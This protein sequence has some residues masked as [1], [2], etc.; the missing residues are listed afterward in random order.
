MDLHSA[1]AE[2]F[3]KYVMNTKNRKK[4]VYIIYGRTVF[5]VLA[6][7][8]QAIVLLLCFTWLA[9]Y[10]VYLTAGLTVL[11]AALIVYI[12]N[13]KS[14][15]AFKLAWIIPIL[16]FPV[17]GGLIYIFLELQPGPRH[18]RKKLKQIQEETCYL[19]PKNQEAAKRLANIDRQAGNLSE[20]LFR[21][22]GYPV[23]EDTEL[24]YFPQ[25]EDKFA[26]L[27]RELEK[28][29]EFIFLEY[30]ILEEG[31]MWD[32]VLEVLKRKAA[33]GVEVRL[34]YD[35]MCCLA[36][37]PYSY[38]SYI[39]R[40]GI[41]CKMFQPIAPVLDTMQNNRD[42]R[43]ILVID[44]KVAFTGGINFADEYINRKIRFGHWKD[45]AIMLKGEAVKSFTL[46]FLQMWNITEKTPEKYER[47]IKAPESFGA[48]REHCPGFVIP[49]GDSPLD[50]ENV[51]EHLYMDILNT[52][53]NYVHIMTPYLIIDNE[54]ITALLYAAK[55]G[56]EVQILLPHIPDKKL[57]FML[58]HSYYP[59]LLEG[60]V[61][62]YEYTPGFIHAKVF[63]SDGKEAVVGTV[64]LDYRSF[65]LHFE[66]GAYLYGCR[67]IQRIEQ[68]F[69][70]TLAK[71]RPMIM[72]DYKKLSP[73]HRL[74]GHILK[75]FAPL[76]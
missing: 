70:E 24:V 51:G 23:Y 38:P 34:M 68:D 74:L 14:N 7:L 64:N 10:Q 56:V 12:L 5:V 36:L 52:A 59:R 50:D 45:T 69:Q 43:K 49:Y 54:M 21:Y 67:E 76:M 63:T 31:E 19:T 9:S 62:I 58:A 60:G 2:G 46:M 66:C 65:Y 28:A 4:A 6:M 27:L 71:C 1:A 42:H 18:V 20:Y 37:L 26:F 72:E 55:R 22:G 29:R 57:A 25:G 8:M 47:Y 35:G 53:R 3:A 11:S 61:K 75:I 16:I 30:F 41:A 48:H 15:P 13:S 73:V 32:A 39:R 17:F 44:G 33:E 40:F